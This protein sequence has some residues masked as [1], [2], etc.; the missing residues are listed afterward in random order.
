MSTLSTLTLPFEGEP[1]TTL[2]WDGQP[3]WVCRQIGARLDY[4]KSGKRL[5]SRIRREWADEF[6]EGKDYVILSGPEL[7]HLKAFAGRGTPGVPSRAG[8]LMLLLESGLHLVLT[9]TDKPI[10]KRLR[11]FLADEVLPQLARTGAYSPDAPPKDTP[12]LVVVS[13]PV[14]E[15]PLSRQREAR[16][17]RQA[18]TRERWVDLCD[19][20]L[21]VA[22][23]HR[24]ID[25]CKDEGELPDDVAAAL[26][27]TAAEIALGADLSGLKPATERWVS[28]TEIGK[29]WGVSANKVGRVITKAGIRG[30]ERFS[31]RV[32]NKARGHNRVVFSFV[33]NAAGEAIIDDLLASEGQQPLDAA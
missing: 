7:A 16:L 25:R 14:R 32:M 26:E 22:T 19:R 11:R 6:I 15:V 18:E 33:Y 1:L 4:A 27:V 12:D 20:R 3:A 24:A 21:K 29:R 31:K 2:T 5:V 23:L 9:R 13:L 28:P 30:D 8:S 17:A 10:G